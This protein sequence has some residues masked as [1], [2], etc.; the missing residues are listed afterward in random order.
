[1]KLN[2]TKNAKRNVMAGVLNKI[3]CLFLPFCLRT[4]MI[5]I[6]GA[7][8]L[9]LNSLFSSILQVLSLSE[10]GVGAA[11][12][13]SMYKAIAEDDKSTICALM[14][15]YKKTYRYIG[16]VFLSMGLLLLPFLK[17]LISGSY[18]DDIN[19]YVVYIVFLLNS[20]VSYFFFAY[21]A[22]ILTA[23][24]KNNITSNVHTAV[25]GMISLLQILMIFL[26]ANY[27]TYIILMV[28]TTFLNNIITAYFSEKY[29]PQYQCQGDLDDDIN[30]KIKKQISGLMI[31]KIC[32]VSR[33]SFDSIFI[34]M[35]LG[36]TASAIYGNYYM[37]ITS[38]IGIIGI[39]NTS[40][41][42]GIGNSIV[43]ETVDKN[44]RDF[45]KFN[46][47]YMLIYGWATICLLCLYQPFMKIWMGEEYMF[48]MIIVLFL[49]IYFYS[50]G[51][52]NIRS[53][54]SDATGLWWENRYRAL[55]EAIVNIILNYFLGKYFGVAGIIIATLVSLL[56]INFGFGSK[57]IFKYYFKNQ[58]SKEYF[59][60]HIRYFIV[61]LIVAII[62]Y[63]IADVIPFAGVVELILKSIV[64]AIIPAVLY[65]IMYS[66]NKLAKESMTWLLKVV[67]KKR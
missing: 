33:N 5:R 9:G 62:T 46:Y 11:I 63:S 6:L 44:Y 35:F 8:Y 3:V 41:T 17:N 29:F 54:Y 23:H 30:K 49:A 39:I 52:G 1:M 67:I 25:Y 55:L 45:K 57:I 13:F 7:E 56:V 66:R 37:I 40:I 19:L 12:T 10:L 27:Y 65:F 2:R 47:I 31:S 42:A 36:L 38:L 24:Q 59:L 21:K 14:N 28:L 60:L 61:T 64:C 15:F 51:I 16:I 18:P 34:S 48:S 53:I 32:G 22:A 20:S 26:F 58:T 4:V 50:L 43:T